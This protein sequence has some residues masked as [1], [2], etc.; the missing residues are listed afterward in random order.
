MSILGQGSVNIVGH[1][2][3]YGLLAASAGIAGAILLVIQLRRSQSSVGGGSV[4]VDPSQQDAG[5]GPSVYGQD[6]GSG[7]AAISQQ[8]A[9]LSAALPMNNAG[10][11]NSAPP[12]TGNASGATVSPAPSAPSY[13]PAAAA[14]Y[15]P[16]QQAAPSPTPSP[17]V[18]AP[19]R[20]P[21][22][23]Y[24]APAAIYA[25]SVTPQQIQATGGAY[26]GFKHGR[27]LI[28]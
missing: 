8:L 9:A 11:A 12:V 22:G 26:T 4:P 1:K 7:L 15:A 21:I 28:S 23:S 17:A 18:G 27:V 6:Y 10:V 3:S 24:W 20:R 2:V 5:Q 25:P 16:P 14:A 13:L 19:L